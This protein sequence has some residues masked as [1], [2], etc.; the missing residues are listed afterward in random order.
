MVL[1]RG[2]GRTLLIRRAA[3]RPAPGYWAPVTGR[4]EANESLEQAALRELHEEVGLRATLGPEIHRCLTAGAPFELRWFDAVLEG[5][6]QPRLD[7]SE[8]AEARWC[9]PAEALTLTP[10]FEETRA[11]YLKF[12]PDQGR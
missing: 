2:D 7:P 10:M 12:A 3:G 11:F 6:P 8:V 5:P 9:T 1:R 4:V